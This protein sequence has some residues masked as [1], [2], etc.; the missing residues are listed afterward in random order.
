MLK[1]TTTRRRHRQQPNR[2][3]NAAC[4]I[5]TLWSTFIALAISESDQLP[6]HVISTTEGTNATRASRNP[7]TH[8]LTPTS[9]FP[10]LQINLTRSSRPKR[11]GRNFGSPLQIRAKN[12]NPP[13]YTS[14]SRYQSSCRRPENQTQ[15]VLV[16]MIRGRDWAKS[17]NFF[18][19]SRCCLDDERV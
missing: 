7:P 13:A 5:H 6:E 10:E 14:Q 18:G 11:G 8:P 1:P 12:T 4:R 2:F 15:G 3:R 16:V 17:C 19:N 9:S